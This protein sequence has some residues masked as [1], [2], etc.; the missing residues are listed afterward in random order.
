MFARTDEEVEEFR[1]KKQII[2]DGQGVPR[3]ITVFEEA[4]F[5]GKTLLFKLRFLLA[6]MSGI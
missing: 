5:P 1:N 6:Y 2:V 3:P 4:S